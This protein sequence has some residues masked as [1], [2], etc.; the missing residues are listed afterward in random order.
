MC[1]LPILYF[2]IYSFR[3]NS[4]LLQVLQHE[5]HVVKLKYDNINLITYMGMFLQFSSAD[6]TT[7]MVKKALS[8]HFKISCFLNTSQS[9][10]I[11]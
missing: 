11:S 9:I 6:V 2:K 3:N 8:I 7:E 10:T 1:R 4:V 5:L